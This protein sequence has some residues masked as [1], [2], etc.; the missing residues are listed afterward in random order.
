MIDRRD[1]VQVLPFQALKEPIPNQ[2]CLITHSRL[3]ESSYYNVIIMY[4]HV[5]VAVQSVFVSTVLHLLPETLPHTRNMKQEPSCSTKAAFL[6]GFTG[7]T[8]TST[9][10]TTQV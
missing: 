3:A 9:N 6:G 2:H 5:F 10:Q 4:Q 8:D 7:L 1:G